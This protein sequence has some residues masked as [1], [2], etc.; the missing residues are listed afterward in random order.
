MLVPKGDRAGR[1]HQ[2][3]ALPLQAWGW[4]HVILL[5]REW[6]KKDRTN[7][8]KSAHMQNDG[9]KMI[10]LAGWAL[11]CFSQHLICCLSTD[12]HILGVK[13][14][15]PIKLIFF[16]L[17]QFSAFQSQEKACWLFDNMLCL[18]IELNNI[19]IYSRAKH[20]SLVCPEVLWR[21]WN[22]SPVP[23]KPLDEVLLC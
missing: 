12:E 4:P 5:L 19:N 7:M 8:G 21:R 16:N 2:R 1:G 11:L 9:G 15:F 3:Q 20:Y 14:F 23:P 18:W 10:F 17:G 6:V 13:K 22:L